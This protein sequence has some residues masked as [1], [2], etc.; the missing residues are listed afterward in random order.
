MTNVLR[1]FTGRGVKEADPS[2]SEIPEGHHWG[3]PGWDSGQEEPETW[4]P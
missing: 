4:G 2:R 1:D 3:L